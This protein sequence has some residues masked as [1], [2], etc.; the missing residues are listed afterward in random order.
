MVQGTKRQN[1]QTSSLYLQT[2][3]QVLPSQLFPEP[4]KV[5]SPRY[6][7]LDG[8]VGR[9][10]QCPANVLKVTTPYRSVQKKKKAG[11]LLVN[12]SNCGLV[13][14][15]AG[16]NGADEKATHRHHLRLSG[17]VGAVVP[18]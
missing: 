2:P 12:A 6:A 5:V 15:V 8:A 14:G 3:M 1:M 16:F 11:N 17:F 18:W 13:V 10:Y 7:R 4:D 9:L